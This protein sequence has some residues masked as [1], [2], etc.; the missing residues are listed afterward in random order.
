MAK[1]RCSAA[2]FTAQ[3]ACICKHYPIRAATVPHL[4]AAHSLTSDWR[5]RYEA[6]RRCINT[7][8]LFSSIPKDT[9]AELRQLLACARTLPNAIAAELARGGT[10]RGKHHE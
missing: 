3:K 4:E 5:N 2:G 10:E 6:P 7:L 8:V 9:C 1:F